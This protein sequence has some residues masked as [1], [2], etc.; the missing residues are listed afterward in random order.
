VALSDTQMVT[1]AVVLGI[2]L[3]VI[4]YNNIMAARGR[5]AGRPSSEE[6][7]AVHPFLAKFARHEGNVVGEVVA[8]SGG[9]LI[10][11]Q[12]GAF[13]A[14]PLAQAS[15]DS[16]E[17]ILTGDIDWNS[18]LAEG[19]AWHGKNRAEADAAVSG[20]LTRSEDVKSPALG[21]TQKREG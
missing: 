2:L 16:G 5:P 18:A 7:P 12:S 21:S 17:V 3:L 6:E 11:K 19:K 15:E 10:L 9:R 14:V 4:V 1:V 13:K 8:V 20:P